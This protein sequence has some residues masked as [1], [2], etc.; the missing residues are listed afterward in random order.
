MKKIYINGYFTCEHING[1]P[2]YANEIVKRLDDYFK[3][4][5][6]E[7]VVPQEA[8]NVPNLKNIN[9]STWEERGK[10]KEVRG[11]LWGDISYAKYVKGQKGLNVNFT[12][13]GEK[14]QNSVS[15]IH[16]LITLEHY[17]YA[18]KMPLK[19]KIGI[20][21]HNVI[22]RKWFKHKLRIKKNYTRYIVTVSEI[23]KKKICEYLNVSEKKVRVIGDGWEHILD[24][25]SKN[26]FKDTRIVPDEYYFSIGNVKPHKNFQWIIKEAQLNPQ[27]FFVI[28]GKI[29]DYIANDVMRERN[30]VIFLGHI[31]D[32]YM[33]YLMENA[34][35][36][37]FPSFTEGFGIPP[38]EALALKT[39]VAVADIPVMREIFGDAVDYFNPYME[40]EDLNS[41]FKVKDNEIIQ[42]VL[43]EHSWKNAA[44]QWK[45]LI[46]ECRGE[47]LC[48]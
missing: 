29:P 43:N 5:E 7:L 18:F 34:K 36:L 21:I 31:T 22:D 8:K 40:Y 26:E 9:I 48:E 47:N 39:R 28:A 23:S 2:R 38:L 44:I 10:N 14:I 11:V 45:K 17:K 1:V 19:Q 42:K 30:N 15:T 6:A 32:N 16:D 20:K 33:K 46:D 24:I 25:E 41:L 4:G 37:L 35:G 13:R 12:N 27:E 3:P